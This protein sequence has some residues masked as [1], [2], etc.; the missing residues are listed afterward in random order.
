MLD[1]MIATD[2]RVAQSFSLVD[3]RLHHDNNRQ[4]LKLRLNFQFGL[5]MCFTDNIFEVCLTPFC[6]EYVILIPGYILVAAEN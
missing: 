5:S 1:T 6:A 2:K 3:R 4:S